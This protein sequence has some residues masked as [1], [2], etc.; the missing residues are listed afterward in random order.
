MLWTVLSGLC[1]WWLLWKK[2]LFQANW[3]FVQV[4]WFGNGSELTGFSRD[5]SSGDIA[6]QISPSSDGSGPVAFLCERWNTHHVIEHGAKKSEFPNGN[7]TLAWP[8]SWTLAG[9]FPF[10]Q[11]DSILITCTCSRPGCILYSL[12]QSSLVW[13]WKVC[14]TLTNRCLTPT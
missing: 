12:Y 8:R 9:E 2:N 13:I 6:C 11:K 1:I 10:W 5:V 7:L 3:L 14:S 4:K